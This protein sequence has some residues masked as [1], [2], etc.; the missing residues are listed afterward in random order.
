MSSQVGMHEPDNGSFAKKLETL[1]L[2][3]KN[4]SSYELNRFSELEKLISN[5]NSKVSN[6]TNSVKKLTNIINNLTYAARTLIS[7]ESSAYNK[8]NRGGDYANL[9]N[10]WYAETG[11]KY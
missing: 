6:I 7:L 5:N 1:N 9:V 8:V 4:I 11:Y 3:L 2:V 10:Q